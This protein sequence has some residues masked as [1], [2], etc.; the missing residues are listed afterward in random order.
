MNP[1]NPY[2]QDTPPNA[3]DAPPVQPVQPVQ[4]AAPPDPQSYLDAIAEQPTNKTRFLSGKMLVV[5]AGALVALILVVVIGVV[6]NNPQQAA[7]DE[8]TALR[9]FA[10]LSRKEARGS[11]WS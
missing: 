1:N 11:T 8:I 5:L 4:S 3:P 9:T 7:K 6:A 10:A 2:E